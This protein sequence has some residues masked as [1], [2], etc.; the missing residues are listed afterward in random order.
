MA[1]IFDKLFDGLNKGV[2]TVGANSK[3][4]IEKA[5]VNSVIENLE[6]EKKQSIELLGMKT[7]ELYMS[8]SE[9]SRDGIANFANEVTKRL[10]L[11]A[12]QQ[13]QLK[14]IGNVY[15]PVCK[16]GHINTQGSRF[17]AGCGGAL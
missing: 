4:M 2:T 10:H 3:A 11:I 12:E 17:C 13:E 9:I 5:K 14:R 15:S 6:R 7:Y 8:G 1:D 16:C